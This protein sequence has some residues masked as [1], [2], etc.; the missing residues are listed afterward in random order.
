ME[1]LLN[2]AL[3]VLTILGYVIYNLYSK[4]VKLEQMV[5]NRDQTLR[6]LSDIINESDKVLKDVDRLG[7]FQSDDEIGFFFNTVKAIQETLNDFTTN[8]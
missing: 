5:I 6:N 8:N 1:T 4:N 2:I 7:A 3:W